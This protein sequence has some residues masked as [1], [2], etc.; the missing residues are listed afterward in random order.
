MKYGNIYK[1]FEAISNMNK[2]IVNTNA[3]ET[4]KMSHMNTSN[5]FFLLQIIFF[6]KSFIFFIPNFFF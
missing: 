4:Y 1:T 6:K 5:F 2:G 3:P